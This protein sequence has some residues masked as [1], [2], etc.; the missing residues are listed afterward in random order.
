MPTSLLIDA[1]LLILLIVGTASRDYI[2]RHKRLRAFSVEDFDALLNI[3]SSVRAL[4]ITPNTLTET[5][6]LARQIAEPAYSEVQRV[7]RELALS[8]GETYV[9]SSD[10]VNRNEFIRLGLT[11]AA[12]IECASEDVALLTTDFDLYQSALAAGAQAYNFNHIRE[13]Y[14]TA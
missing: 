13:T 14:L 10:A 11:D 9:A 2:A 7:F 6:N 4:V 3:V 5:S 8:T 12:L 1:N